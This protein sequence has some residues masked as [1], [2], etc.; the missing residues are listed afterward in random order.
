MNICPVKDG[1]T[2]ETSNKIY[3]LSWL[4]HAARM[5]CSMCVTCSLE[6]RGRCR[7]EREPGSESRE[8]GARGRLSR[9]R[10]VKSK[11]KQQHCCS[12]QPNTWTKDK[13][14]GS[15]GSGGVFTWKLWLSGAYTWGEN[16]WLR[17]VRMVW[18]TEKM[19]RLFYD[20]KIAMEGRDVAQCAGCLHEALGTT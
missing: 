18:R 7:E 10:N 1:A 9:Q 3:L 13:L 14:V 12:W 17:V 19:Y 11:V 8:V 20:V 16:Q 4:Q 5:L 6:V 2:E 15:G